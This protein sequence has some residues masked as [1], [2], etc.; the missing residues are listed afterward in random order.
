MAHSFFFV[1]FPS[2]PPHVPRLPPRPPCG[3][4]ELLL[5]SFGISQQHA[6]EIVSAFHISQLLTRYDTMT[7]EK[8]N[9]C[10]HALA[11]NKGSTLTLLFRS[12]VRCFPYGCFKKRS[13]ID[14]LVDT[15]N[16]ILFK[17]SSFCF[18]VVV[19]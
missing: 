7:A 6:A 12:N 18:A 17:N 15:R 19:D 1:P 16:F 8:S 5:R 11:D 4:D 10:F 2:Q 14:M 3:T 9:Q 13:G